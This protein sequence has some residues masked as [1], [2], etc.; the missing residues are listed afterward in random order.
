V[1]VQRRTAALVDVPEWSWWRLVVAEWDT[2]SADEQA[3][4]EAEVFSLLEPYR[5]GQPLDI[6]V[7]LDLATAT[8]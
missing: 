5:V 7:E 1:V 4:V 2:L 6:P 8:R 3:A